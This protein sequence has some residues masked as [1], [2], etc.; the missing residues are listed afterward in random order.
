[1]DAKDI[2]ELRKRLRMS[3]EK[4]AHLLG[5]SMVTV[6]RWEN[7]HSKPST[8]YITQMKKLGGGSVG[9]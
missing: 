7:G 1:M 6:N 5:A 4:F 3:Q 9:V 8:I 2:I